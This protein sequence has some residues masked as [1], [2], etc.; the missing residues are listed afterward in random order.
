MSRAPIPAK[1]QKTVLLRSGNR[2]AFTNCRERLVTEDEH[3]RAMSTTGEIAHIRAESPGGPRHDSSL[4]VEERNSPDNLI[5]LC[6]AHH[7]LIDDNPD[8][9]PVDS[10]VAMKEF[11]EKNIDRIQSLYAGEVTHKELSDVCQNLVA[12]QRAP[13]S[14]NLKPPLTYDE[15]ISLNGL[16]APVKTNLQDA[17]VMVHHVTGFVKLMDSTVKNYGRKLSLSVYGF[18]ID[19]ESKQLTPNQIYDEIIESISQE[20]LLPIGPE[21]ATAAHSVAAYLFERCEIFENSQP[22]SRPILVD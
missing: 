5:Y 21:L 4:S 3:T 18:Y 20:S 16:T 13:R 10:L 15:K 19:A 1:H 12:S 14:A 6:H 8:R 9:Y 2:C 22:S 11:H 17:F 7:K